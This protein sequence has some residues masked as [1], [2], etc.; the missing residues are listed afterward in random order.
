MGRTHTDTQR[1]KDRKRE[2][3]RERGG[4]GG[5][6]ERKRKR[7]R[8]RE[9]ERERRRRRYIVY[10]IKAG[11]FISYLSVLL[12]LRLQATRLII[13]FYLYCNAEISVFVTQAPPDSRPHAQALAS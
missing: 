1:E 10:Y 9:R 12:V 7:E 8:E 6:R 3:E 5:E 4:G 11:V 2:I 13:W